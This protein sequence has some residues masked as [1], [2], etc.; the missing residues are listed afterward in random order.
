MPRRFTP[1]SRI[2]GVKGAKMI[3]IASEGSETEP[4]YFNELKFLSKNPNVKVF[5][6]ERE[7]HTK[8]SPEHV[9][10]MLDEFREKYSELEDHDEFW[11]VVDK[12][13]WDL[14]NAGRLCKQKGYKMAVSNPSFELWL[15]LHLKSLDEYDS[16][17][18][19][20]FRVNQKV[21]KNRTRVEKELLD[22][23]GEYNKSNPKVKEHFCPHVGDAI[24]R[25]R[26]L[27]DSGR[28]P[29]D[30]GSKVYLIAEKIS[31]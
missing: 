9:I 26:K 6:L 17:T 20:E 24:K 15:L 3:V 25:A 2:S 28:W 10:Q 11:V 31:R 21:G 22:I 19:E 5:A 30:L 14:E 13:R 12:D 27:D 18:L 16:V 8:S 1:R 29:N 4:K 23:L 7:D